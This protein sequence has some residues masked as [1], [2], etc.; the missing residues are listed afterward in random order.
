MYSIVEIKGKQFKAEEGAKLYVPHLQADE[1]ET[2]TFDRVLLHV[3]GEDVKVGAPT[4][5]GQEVTA[6]V[7]GHVKG[8]KVTVFKKKRRK[9]YRVKR[10][11]RQLYTQI[12]IESLGA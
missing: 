11:H 8:D 2:V 4:V 5:D 1:D 6:T 10:G 9:R 12:Q 3:D 7:L